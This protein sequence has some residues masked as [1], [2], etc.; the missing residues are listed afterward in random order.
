MSLNNQEQD[1]QKR[2]GFLSALQNQIQQ[3]LPAVGISLLVIMVGVGST[4]LLAYITGNPLSNLTKDPAQIL[5]YP[6]YIGWLSNLGGLL[7]IAT[8]T[9]CLFSS[10]ILR[11]QGGSPASIN[12]MRLSGLINVYLGIDDLFLLHDRAFPELFHLHE[13]PF[14]MAY[15]LLIIA[16]LI[17]FLRYILARDYLLLFFAG[18][19][20]M[21]SR[22]AFVLFPSLARFSAQGDMVKFAGIIFWLAFF[23]RT[24]FQEVTN[25]SVQD[26]G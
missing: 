20:L 3:I 7:W 4:V 1:Q 8:A 14:Y 19:L 5:H 6:L 22:G 2:T 10:V 23:Y 13:F 17:Y 26:Q 25:P 16:Y 11:R 24:A 9:L 18:F 15:I 12:F 21:A